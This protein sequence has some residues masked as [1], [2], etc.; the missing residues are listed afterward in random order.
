MVVSH[1]ETSGELSYC[2][3]HLCVPCFTRNQC[4]DTDCRT[5]R[6]YETCLPLTALVVFMQF[7]E[8]TPLRLVGGNGIV[9][10]PVAAGVLIEISTRIDGFIHRVY[11]EADQRLRLS[12]RTAVALRLCLYCQAARH[13]P[14]R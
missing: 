6:I 9:L 14:S 3:W 7:V 2:G 1:C 8:A 12:R 11:I 4:W 13:K 10:D 5:L